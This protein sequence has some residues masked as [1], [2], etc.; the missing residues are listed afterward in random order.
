MKQGMAFGA[1][2]GGG[3]GVDVGA[4]VGNMEAAG[5]QRTPI[6]NRT[7]AGGAMGMQ[8]G[9]GMAQWRQPQAPVARHA[10]QR[11]PFNAM[12]DQRSFRTSG[13]TARSE[14][15]DSTTE[16]E[17]L[18][19]QTGT[20]HGGR[21]NQGGGAQ[22]SVPQHRIAGAQAAVPRGFGQPSSKRTGPKFK[23]ALGVP[24]G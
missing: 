7:M 2:I 23:P 3:G 24:M 5:I 15:S 17:N 1:G 6:V 10:A 22:W 18:I 9:G 4:V 12:M 19:A 13:S 14:H 21:S 11:Q 20:R 8:A 16:V